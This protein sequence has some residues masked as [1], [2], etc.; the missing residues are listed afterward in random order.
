[1]S[2]TT[3]QP[4]PPGD[5]KRALRVLVVEDSEF[6]TRMLVG[7]LRAGGFE[8]EFERVETEGGMRAALGQAQWEVILADYNLP[9]FSAPRALELLQESQLDIPF[10]IV[11]GGIGEDTAVAAMKS[12][13]NDYLMKGNLA[14]LVPAVERELREAAVRAS[15]RQT[16]KD[17]RVSELRHRSLIE[18]TSDI[19]AVLDCNGLIQFV[20]PACERVLGTSAEAL[21]NCDWFALAHEEDRDR[22]RAEFGQALGQPGKQIAIE[23]RFVAV[24]GSE[25]VMDATARNLLDDKAI[26]GVVINAHDI[27]ERLKAQAA[28]HESEEQ[29]RVAS[30]IQQHLFPRKAPQLDGFDIAGAS[31][32]AAATGGDYFDYLTTSD[33]QLALAIGDVSGHGI[34]PAM[35]MA[36]TRAYLRILT[37]NRNDLSLIL[38]RA[39]TVVGDDVGEDRFVTMLLAKLD[40]EKGT[41]VHA[42]A[43]HTPA[44]ILGSD[45]GVKSELRRTGM[46]LGVM[47][48]AEYT[49]SKPL[50]LAKGDVVVLLTDGL[51]ETANPEGELFGLDRILQAVHQSRQSKATKIVESVFEIL[52]GFSGSGEQVDD[53]TMIVAKVE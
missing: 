6:D 18:N 17:L 40:P 44:F 45:G 41:L 7:L 25:R 26:G 20:S 51:E 38:T 11:S 34:G 4:N 12:G 15:R 43:G 35:L 9:D 28:M 46:P 3:A 49:V 52:R 31:K 24:D 33:G 1:M 47:R 14:R 27:T 48:G 39:N 42:S 5:G 37:R 53:L 23:G 50:R 10:I 32:P 22:L 19:I 36:E 2:E 21:I 30:E 8:P 16:V 29:F 13:A